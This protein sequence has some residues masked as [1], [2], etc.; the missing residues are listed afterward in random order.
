[1]TSIATDITID[2][3]LAVP[4]AA[5]LR[6]QIEYGIVYGKIPR[7]GRLPPVREL[8]AQ[9][10][11]SLV[12][13]AQVYK[14]LQQKGL[15]VSTPGRGTYVADHADIDKLLTLHQLVE[16]SLRD[17]KRQAHELGLSTPD[18]RHAIEHK[19][20]VLSDAHQLRVSFVGIFR[21]VSQSYVQDLRR[22]LNTDLHIDVVTLQELHDNAALLDDLANADLI[23]TF[24][25]RETEVR[26][27]LSAPVP[28][29]SIQFIPSKATR[30]ALA[31]LEPD[32]RLALV[33]ILPEF[34]PVLKAG[35]G[36]FASHIF[37]VRAS[38]RGLDD[39]DDVLRWA[40]V[41][42]Y[43]SGSEALIAALPEQTR[44]F[45][46]LHSPDP[47]SVQGTLAP[48]LQQLAPDFAST[49]KS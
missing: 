17:L 43:A 38:A 13:V 23:I 46:Y 24:R 10:D 14:E 27:L 8:A 9:L 3:S 4:L 18:V 25:H 48:I 49:S 42:V 30:M 35:V 41:V 44:R 40:D 33:T 29:V 19:L 7:G 15:I 12:T 11:I 45:E 39:L 36:T 28:V 1:M 26:Q 47:A 6:A 16:R 2:R 34:L 20:H 31:A 5:Q 37:D 32:T 21:G 22:Q